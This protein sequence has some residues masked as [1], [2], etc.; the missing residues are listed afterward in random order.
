MDSLLKTM[1]V[2]CRCAYQHTVGYDS[3][4]DTFL[5]FDIYDETLN[6]GAG[7]FL[8]SACS[9]EESSFTIDES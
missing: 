5:A 1:N 9:I 6:A 8:S 4:P 7:G 3:L 2:S